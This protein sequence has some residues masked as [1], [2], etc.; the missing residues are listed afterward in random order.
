[1]KAIKLQ[2]KQLQDI[3]DLIRKMEIEIDLLRNIIYRS[4]LENSNK[5]KGGVVNVPDDISFGITASN[6]LKPVFSI[7]NHKELGIESNY[8]KIKQLIQKLS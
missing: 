1:M 7:T 2:T 5:I 8:Q 4:F 3:E 6:I